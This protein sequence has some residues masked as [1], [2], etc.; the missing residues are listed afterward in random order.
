MHRIE[1][2]QKGNGHGWHPLDLER[3][4]IVY[5]FDESSEEFNEYGDSSPKSDG[6]GETGLILAGDLH[7]DTYLD[8]ANRVYDIEGL[9]PTIHCRTGGGNEDKD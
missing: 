1:Q 7:N 3:E 5:D 4:S 8:V 6:Q 2:S 9:S